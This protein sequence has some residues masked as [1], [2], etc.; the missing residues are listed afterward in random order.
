MELRRLHERHPGVTEFMAGDLAGAAAMCF[1]RHHAGGSV[2]V[3]VDADDGERRSSAAWDDPTAEA[4]RAYANDDDATRDGAYC[5]ALAATEE[6]IAL[7]ALR[8]AATRTGADWLLVPVDAPVDDDDSLDLER[9]DILRLEVSG[10]D[11]D[12]PTR[13]RSRMRE[14]LEQARDGASLFPSMACVVGFA[15]ATVQLRKA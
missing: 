1:A 2:G 7:K 11:Q 14:K 15:S 10:I 12:T 13:L 9:D 4:R 5:V 3:S 8:R 6:A